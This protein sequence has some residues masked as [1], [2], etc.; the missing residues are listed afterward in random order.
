MPRLLRQG[1]THSTKGHRV[2]PDSTYRDGIKVYRTLTIASITIDRRIVRNRNTIG[3]ILLS[4]YVVCRYKV[5]YCAILRFVI[6]NA[7]PRLPYWSAWEN[8]PHTERVG[9]KSL[10]LLPIKHFKNAFLQYSS[11]PF[12]I[13][14]FSRPEFTIFI[15]CSKCTI[16]HRVIERR[17]VS[18]DFILY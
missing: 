7:R 16:F 2:S 18:R 14:M 13:Y 3:S 1:S 8:L 6:W 9:T 15:M 17:Y 11:S 12:S 4:A 10:S 5:V